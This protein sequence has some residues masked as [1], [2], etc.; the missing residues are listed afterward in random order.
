MKIV[1]RNRS[2]REGFAG[3][4]DD[5]NPS[6]DI[7]VIDLDP[8]TV[9][10]IEELAGLWERVEEADR[11]ASELRFFFYGFECY[12]AEDID[13]FEDSPFADFKIL[14][15]EAEEDW[16]AARLEMQEICLSP[17]GC[18]Q[19][20]CVQK[21]SDEPVTSPQIYGF[22]EWAQSVFPQPA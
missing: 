14:P 10:R 17:G 11:D 15:E 20:C 1:C 18:I 2:D 19:F 16:Q 9:R 3:F 21:H 6:P 4:E 8:G 22:R 13:G 12:G 5:D 7:M